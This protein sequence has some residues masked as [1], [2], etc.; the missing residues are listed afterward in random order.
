MKNQLKRG[1]EIIFDIS[2]NILLS[3][4]LEAN[5]L[6]S[7][8]HFIDFVLEN[9]EEYLQKLKPRIDFFL[10]DEIN[11]DVDYKSRIKNDEYWFFIYYKDYLTKKRTLI[12]LPK[13]KNITQSIKLRDLITHQNNNKIIEGV[14]IQYKNIKGKRLKLLF[15]AFQDLNLLP[16]ERNAQKFHDCCKKEFDWNIASYNSMNGYNFND[17]IDKEDFN[18]MKEYLLTLL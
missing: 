1:L 11:S 6:A 17:N 12:N 13:N 14:K 3:E 16:R 18:S 2:Y 8:I 7:E 15:L 9:Q 5:V 10:N 4:F